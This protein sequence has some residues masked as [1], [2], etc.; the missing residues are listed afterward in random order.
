MK[1]VCV[2]FESSSVLRGSILLSCNPRT[3]WVHYLWQVMAAGCGETWSLII[4]S[5]SKAVVFVSKRFNQF[6][7]WIVEVGGEAYP[8]PKRMYERN[9]LPQWLNQKQELY[10]STRTLHPT[11]TPG[12]APLSAVTRLCFMRPLGMSATFS[13]SWNGG[14]KHPL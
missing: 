6:G 1:L 5:L 2:V 12:N 13:A 7:S 14:T 10:P 8:L 4:L 3:H 11:L 9:S